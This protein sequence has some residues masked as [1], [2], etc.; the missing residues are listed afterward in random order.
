MTWEDI[1]DGDGEPGQIKAQVFDGQGHRVGG[2]F[3]INGT[4]QD[5]QHTPA[6]AALSGGR[7]IVTWTDNSGAGATTRTMASGRRSS[8]SAVRPGPAVKLN[9]AATSPTRTV[10]SARRLGFEHSGRR[11]F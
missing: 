6:I 10:R 4:M 1:E 3:T 9:L 11:D 5:E 2:E 8:P 7:F